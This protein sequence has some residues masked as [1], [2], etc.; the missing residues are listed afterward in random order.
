[1]LVADTRKDYVRTIMLPAEQ[2]QECVSEVVKELE[3]QG[4]AALLNE[5]IDAEQITLERF[6]DMRYTGQSYELSV[7]LEEK[8]AEAVKLFHIAHQQRFGYSNATKAVQI[9]NVRLKGRGRAVRPAFACQECLSTQEACP[10]ST[11]QVGFANNEGIVY[12]QTSIYQRSQ[13]LAGM[14]LAGPALV[15]Q[16]DTTIVIP[17]GWWGRIDEVGNLVLEYKEKEC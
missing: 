7:P 3:E 5:G 11:H 15:V 4:R 9:V 6:L 14:R 12:H 17:P 16:Y 1:M 8:V 10:V 2:A 13:L